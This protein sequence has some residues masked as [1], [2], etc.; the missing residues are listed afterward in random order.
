M[1][2]HEGQRPDQR[3]LLQSQLPQRLT[4]LRRRGERLREGWDVNTLALLG[5]DAGFLAAALSQSGSGDIADALGELAA[6]V[7][8]LLDP[9]RTPDQASM[10]RLAARLAALARFEPVA[11]AEPSIEDEF[12]LLAAAP[13]VEWHSFASAEPAP[14]VPAPPP[15]PRQ[16]PVLDEEEGARLEA[17]IA[18]AAVLEQSIA[19]DGLSSDAYAGFGHAE[20]VARTNGIAPP[21]T[22]E[23]RLRAALD[24]DGL[25]LMFQPIVPLHGEAREQFQAL[26]R[27]RGG[28]GRMYTAADLIPAA[29]RAGLLGAIDRWALERCIALIAQRMQA[30]R[31]MRLFVNQSLHSVRNAWAVTRIERLLGE[32][33][34]GAQAISLELRADEADLAP[35]DVVRYAHAVKALGCGFVLSAFETGE[36]GERLLAALPFDA[37]R[38]SPRHLQLADADARE[39]LR[40]LVERLHEQG[41]RVIAPR[42]EDARI[43]SALWSAGVD[44]VQGN[45]VQPADSD[46]GFDFRGSVI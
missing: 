42:V 24:G 23:A 34:I 15:A 44:Y 4:R 20:P 3:S 35:I 2:A 33:R 5:D 14:A 19:A 46:L 1:F 10:D 29:E 38:L 7:A 11:I 40:A 9:P 13:P 17:L 22:L 16:P 21:D 18:A 30:G 31:A 27:L 12:P 39:E 28:D 32:Y 43:A 26:L 6:A 8:P 41:R 25:E 37:V 45:F 36:T